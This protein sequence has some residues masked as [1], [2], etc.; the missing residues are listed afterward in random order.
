M[1]TCPSS[2]LKLVLKSSD[3]EIEEVNRETRNEVESLIKSMLP[4]NIDAIS[5]ASNYVVIIKRF[6][7]DAKTEELT[8]KPLNFYTSGRRWG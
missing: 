2:N 1:R 3:I 4:K 5:S 6:K 7:D 8:R